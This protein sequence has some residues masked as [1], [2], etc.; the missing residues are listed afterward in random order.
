MIWPTPDELERLQL[1]FTSVE[2]TGRSDDHPLEAERIWRAVRGELP[3]DEVEEMTDQVSRSPDAAAAWRFAVEL[4]RELDETRDGAVVRIDRRRPIR[5]AVGLA[6]AAA[7]VIGVG[8]PVFRSLAP[9]PTPVF[10]AADQFEIKNELPAGQELPR[11]AIELR[12]TPAG[13]GALYDIVL[14][15]SG[16]AVLDRASFLEEPRYVPPAAALVGLPSGAEVWWKID[17]TRP[18]GSRV[19][20]PTFV[21][22][23][24]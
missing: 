14:T 9:D 17:V 19:S 6:A 23:V 11:D 21:N 5:W 12:W 8:L 1:A 4:S 20:S 15:D 13:E 3:P 18:D 7:V 10:R 24:R 22:R 16:L 2:A